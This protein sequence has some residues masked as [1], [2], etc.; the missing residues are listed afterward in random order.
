MH[1]NARDHPTSSTHIKKERNIK[2]MVVYTW[3]GGTLATANEFFNTRKNTF[4]SIL[5][6]VVYTTTTIRE[7]RFISRQYQFSFY[8]YCIELHTFKVLLK[9]FYLTVVVM[10]WKKDII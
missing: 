7:T 1:L 8:Y 2:K 3:L 9:G 6:V 4:C 10:P 5:L